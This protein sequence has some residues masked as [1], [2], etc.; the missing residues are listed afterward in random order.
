VD[1]RC[2]GRPDRLQFS[3]AQSQFEK[4]H[5]VKKLVAVC[6]LVCAFPLFTAG[7]FE[8]SGMMG[9]ANLPLAIVL[10]LAA[11]AVVYSAGIIAPRSDNKVGVIRSVAFVFFLIQSISFLVNLFIFIYGRV[12]HVE[13]LEPEELDWGLVIGASALL[14]TVVAA[15]TWKLSVKA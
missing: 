14:F 3:Y 1:A 6:L 11:Q 7:G 8:I 12:R 4:L 5:Q 15:R 10:S 13:I 2:D 9:A